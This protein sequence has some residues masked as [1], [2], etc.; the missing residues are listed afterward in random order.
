M[1]KKLKKIKKICKFK[2]FWNS[3]LSIYQLSDLLTWQII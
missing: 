3:I 1:I 2:K